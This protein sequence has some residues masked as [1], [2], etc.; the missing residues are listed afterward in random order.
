M[1]NKQ[2]VYRGGLIV[3]SIPRDW[4]EQYEPEGGG[5]F[6]K[7]GDTTGT[8]WLEVMTL[9][10]P[11][12]ITADSA[13]LALSTVL[14]LPAET[15]ENG[16]ALA[17]RVTQTTDRGQKITMH[18]WH[19]SASLPPET[20]R[21]ANFTYTVL[22]SQAQSPTTLDDLSFLEGSIRQATFSKEHGV[23]PHP[24]QSTKH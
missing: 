3:F 20:I 1:N 14:G 19:L 12:A 7:E 5:M 9:G 11:A 6:F 8:L 18:S 4:I 16:N 22:A 15:L 17:K 23:T 24:I 21:L 2:V 13:R 10:S